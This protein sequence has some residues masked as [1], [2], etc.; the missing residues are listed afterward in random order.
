MTRIGRYE[1][2]YLSLDFRGEPPTGTVV[3]VLGLETEDR[4]NGHGFLW[5]PP[6]PRPRSVVA[7]MHPRADFTRH[8]AVP[9]LLEAGYAV[10]T[11]NSRSVGNDSMLVHEPILL[12]IAAGV[13]R[14]RELGFDRA[15][16]LEDRG[17]LRA[18]WIPGHL[19]ALRR[20]VDVGAQDARHAAQRLLVQPQARRAAD[21]IEDQRRL[22]HALGGRRDELLLRGRIVVELHRR[23]RLRAH[24]GRG[25]LLVVFLEAG[26][27]DGARH[28]LA[29]R[30]TKGALGPEDRRA[31][32]AGSQDRQAAVEAGAQET[33]MRLPPPL[34]FFG[35]ESVRTPSLYSAL[36]P[37][38]ST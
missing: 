18:R 13:R 16:R 4:A 22:A 38:E 24:A 15:D 1:N 26:G 23:Q 35:N 8:Y 37:L 5:L 6:G 29:A 12:D 7:F 2:P 28:R 36:A 19:R 33:V 21:A 32:P 25:A 34:P 20:E 9:P 27:D 3:Q 30:A 17:E 11:Q 31:M 14:M 10:L